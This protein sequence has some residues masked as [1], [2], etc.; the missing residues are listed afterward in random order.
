V[1]AARTLYDGYGYGHVIQ[2]ADVPKYLSKIELTARRMGSINTIQGAIAT[3][4]KQISEIKTP[5][6]KAAYKQLLDT[7]LSRSSNA[8]EKAVRVAIE[9]KSRYQAERIARTEYSRAYG[10]GFFAKIENDSDVKGFRWALS[11][12]HPALDICDFYSNADQYGLGKGVFPKD[13]APEYPAHPHCHC[14]LE[15]VYDDKG[16]GVFKKDAGDKYLS[17]LSSA[18]RS[19]LLGVEGSKAWSQGDDWRN[20]MRNYSNPENPKPI[21]DASM[22]IGDLGSQSKTIMEAEAKAMAMGVKIADYAN[23]ILI[24]NEVNVA[25][26]RIV[27]SGFPPPESLKIS[28][29][30]FKRYPDSEELVA[31]F[32]P[33]TN[34]IYFNPLSDY[35]LTKYFEDDLTRF[36]DKDWSTTDSHHPIYHEYGHYLHFNQGKWNNK[37]MLT[38]IQKSIIWDEVSFYATE[39]SREFVA[40]VTA[41]ILTGKNYSKSIM[42]LFKQVSEF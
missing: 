27:N 13:K 37:I 7:S 2:S 21:L 6:L 22:F 23:N 5:S 29:E 25:V 12:N 20:H 41:G 42:S 18:D 28:E 32:L 33:K 8:L 9:E 3:A 35:Y 34:T 11:S 16:N 10:E 19:K 15:E 39:T 17:S 14:I 31:A 38:E 36:V 30:F 1:D 4:K 24:A 26:S 40:E